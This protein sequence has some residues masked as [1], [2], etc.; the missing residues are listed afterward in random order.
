[1]RVQEA[2]AYSLRRAA[3]PR[4]ERLPSC[5]VALWQVAR[6]LKCLDE[7]RCP[8]LIVQLIDAKHATQDAPRLGVGLKHGG[9]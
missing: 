4:P 7:D 5:L 3:Q 6:H 1:M 2:L 9:D 8:N